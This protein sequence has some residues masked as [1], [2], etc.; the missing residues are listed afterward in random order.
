MNA[1][2]Q[3]E[4]EY[5]RERFNGVKRLESPDVVEQRARDAAGWQESVEHWIGAHPHIC[6]AAALAVGVGI[7]WLVKRR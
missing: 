7:G 2:S 6:V 3:A 5:L 4:L 1:A